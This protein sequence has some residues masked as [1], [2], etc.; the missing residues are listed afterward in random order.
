MSERFLV[1]AEGLLGP[2]SS[3]TASACIRYTPDR[4]AAVIDSTKAGRVVQDFLGFGGDIPIV[5]TLEEGLAHRPNAVLIG[6]APAGGQLPAEWRQMLVT[7][8]E[9]GLDVWSGLHFFLADDEQ[10]SAAARRGSARIF[11]LRRPPAGLD[12]STGKTRDIDATVVL[13]VGTDCNIGKMTAQLQLRDVLK[14]RGNRV[15]FAATGQ[16]GILI[17]GWGISVDA[18]VADFIG[19]AAEQLTLQAA[20]D[21]DIVLVE[22]Q[23]S[24]IHPSFSGVTVGLIHGTLPHAF[25]LCA[26][27]SRTRI[28]NREW[29]PIPPLDEFIRMHDTLAAPLRPAPTIAVALNTSDLSD[30]DARAAI[31]ETESLTGLPATDP[32]RYDA[33]P[34]AEA[35]EAFHRS[36]TPQFASRA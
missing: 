30:A 4:V 33:A 34:I 15:A 9:R 10:L 24:I 5:A 31:R 3:K 13:T 6:I 20:K 28:R 36:R 25:V 7:S 22:G 27:P 21:A 14:Q 19:G 2:H 16:T 8:L 35:I 23:G 26:Q 1:L 18:V 17:E 11:D 12:V 29:V 32:V